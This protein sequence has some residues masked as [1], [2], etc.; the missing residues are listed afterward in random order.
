MA[1][2]ARWKC[3]ASFLVLSLIISP[4]VFAAANNSGQEKP[5]QAEPDS[6]SYLPPWMQGQS[7]SETSSAA[8]ASEAPA[9]NTTPGSKSAAVGD[10]DPARKKA[11]AGSQEQRSHRHGSLPDGF[12]SHFVGLFGR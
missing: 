2:C 9:A 6:K 4:A 7:G 10:N 5:S 11:R 12:I 1:H 3:G 8:A